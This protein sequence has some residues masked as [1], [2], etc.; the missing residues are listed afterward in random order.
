MDPQTAASAYKQGT[1]ENAPAIKIVRM[2]YEGAIRFLDRA[3]DCD[4]NQA[5]SKF[6]YWLSRADDVVCELRISL[7]YEAG[8]EVGRSLEDLYLYCEREIGKALAERS[9]ENITNARQVLDTLNGAWIE[10]ERQSRD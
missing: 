1:I 5:G 3:L 7:N 8:T 9:S 4:P 10:L 6:S 2:M